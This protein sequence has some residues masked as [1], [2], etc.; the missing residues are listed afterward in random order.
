MR[1]AQLLKLWS[2]FLALAGLVTAWVLEAPTAVR[3]G[4][5]AASVTVGL[6]LRLLANAGQILYEWRRD[7]LWLLSR[8]QRD[9]ARWGRET[10]RPE[11]SSPPAGEDG[12]DPLR[13][14]TGESDG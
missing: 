9:L 10:V 5:A 12:E 13:V 11:P 14:E 7:H 8:L 6:L 2:F 1:T 4:V 3:L